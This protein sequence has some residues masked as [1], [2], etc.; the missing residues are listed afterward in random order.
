MQA[1]SRSSI[2]ILSRPDSQWE[3]CENWAAYANLTRAGIEAEGVRIMRSD[4]NRR[5]R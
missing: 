3:L 5:S 2:K 4:L 1:E